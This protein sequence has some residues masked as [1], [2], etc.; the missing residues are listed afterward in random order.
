[1]CNS[2]FR[3]SLRTRR[4]PLGPTWSSLYYCQPP[5]PMLALAGLSSHHPQLWRSRRLKWQGFQFSLS[6]FYIWS[7]GTGVNFSCIPAFPGTS[8]IKT[9]SQSK[10][11][12]ILLLLDPWLK[13]IQSQNMEKKKKNP[14]ICSKGLITCMS[15]HTDYQFPL[16]ILPTMLIYM[17][18]MRKSWHRL[19]I[20][21]D[22]IP[23]SEEW[24]PWWILSMES[25]VCPSERC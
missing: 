6:L 1:M 24:S 25:T 16:S 14:K 7:P 4:A 18:E 12:M 5:V 20:L 8:C 11:E 17:N 23:A 22:F 2:N 10:N 15:S 21:K 3:K 9:K 19:F 13:R